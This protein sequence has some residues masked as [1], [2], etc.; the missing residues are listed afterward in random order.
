MYLAADG[1]CTQCGT[2]LD[3]GWH[4]DHV[5]PYSQGGHT[6]VT[7]GQAMC[8]ACNL[9]KGGK[10]MELRA[11]QQ[12]AL[13][14]FTGLNRKDFLVSATPGAGKTK[15][16]LHLAQ[17]LL[18]Q[19]VVSRVAVV[20]PSDNLREQ[21]ASEAAAQG[22]DLYPVQEPE[23]YDK[24]GFAGCVATYQQLAMGTGKDMMRRALRRPTLVILDEI[25]HAG[26]NKSW[27]DALRYA[28]ERAE[29]RLCLTGT[30]WR[31]DST[32]P[33]PFVSYDANGTVVVDY[34]YEYGA[35]VAD[36]VCRRIE[37]HAYDGEARWTDPFR[38]HRGA[39]GSDSGNGDV[40]IEFAAKLGANM[41]DEDVSAALDTVYEPKYE[42]MP[43]ILRQADEMLS[44]LR[45]EIP[46]AAGL[47]VAERQWHAQGYATLLEKL[48]G[49]RPPVIVSDPKSDPGSKLARA[50]IERFKKGTGRWIVAV[51]MISEG[52]DIPRLAV[53]VYASKTQTP[54][55]FRQVVGR[56]VRTR[57]GEE[58]NARLLIPAVPELLRHA[59]EIEEELRHQL[60]IAEKE[61][62][63]ARARN[64]SG[65]QG[66]LDARTPLSASESVFDRAILSG[67]EVA[68]EELSAAQE[69]CGRLGIPKMFASNLVPL[70]RAQ[71]AAAATVAKSAA[72]PVEVPRFRLEKQ[73]RQEI[74]TLTR[75][76]DYRKGAV[77]GTTNT[78]LLRAGHPKRKT[79]SVE[80]LQKIRATLLRWLEES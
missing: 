4:G 21:W 13:D 3:K 78:D 33:I 35:A 6:D 11:W 71:G 31:R 36:S 49:T 80:E 37:F 27:G 46:D 34:A 67:D 61:V 43:S 14:A 18:R 62:D 74:E 25:H 66:E 24:I 53:G 44:D 55:F 60:D 16:S 22:I 32:S 59:R 57:K 56:F 70:L 52:V 10:Y 23:D 51:K 63:N 75:Q 8:P 42:W 28:V 29:Y 39:N 65:I 77:K 50:D 7:N 73:L 54:L 1:T 76:I 2:Q 5:R 41:A 68:P 58:I 19:G 9:A 69:Q 64:A 17:E 12:E 48:T 30:P 72:Q 45:E 47:V 26:D 40:R 20:V 15:F 79:A 38:A